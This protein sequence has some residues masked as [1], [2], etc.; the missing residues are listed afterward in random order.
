VSPGLS[1]HWKE[2]LSLS[3]RQAPELYEAGATIPPG[4][5]A[6]AIRFALSGLN[7]AAVFCIEGVPTIAFMNESN[8]GLDRID[9]IH[10]VLWNQGLLS[11]LLVIRPDE[12]MA[13]SLVRR[14]FKRDPNSSAKDTRLITSLSLI[15]DALQLRHL[16]ESTESGRFWYEH[17]DFFDPDQRV[18]KVLLENLLQSFRD[19]KDDLGG[20]AAQA[21][22]MQAMFIAYLED[23]KLIKPSAFQEAAGQSYSNFEQVLQ[24]KS[25]TPFEK[26]FG[27]LKTAFNGNVFHT[28]CSFETNGARIPT[29]KLE[30]LKILARFRRGREEMVTGQILL[31]GYDFQY[32]PIALI[33]AVYDRFLKEEAGKKHAEGAFYTP[34][35]LADVVVDQIWAELSEEQRAS[36]VF[37]DPACGSGI[38]L[39]RLFQRLVANHCRLKNKTHATWTELVALAHRVHGGDINASAVRVA[40]CSLYIA[41]LESS[42]PPNLLT[43]IKKG[44]LLPPLYGDT[45]RAEDFFATPDEGRYVAVVGNPPWKGRAGQITTAQTWAKTENLPDPAKDIAWGFIW[46]SLRV[47]APGGFV[48]LLLPAMG[49]LHNV[50]PETQ[51]A[52]RQF[53]CSTR[54]KRIINLSDLCFQLFDDAQRP[55]AFAIYQATGSNAAEPYSF[56]YWTPKADF[57]LRL[58]RILTLARSDRI[59]LRSDMVALDPSVFKRRLWTRS[60]DEKLLQYLNT[61]PPMSAFI[62]QFKEL[63]GQKLDRKTDWVIGQGFK[64]AQEERIDDPKYQRTTAPDVTK[65]PY[66]DANAFEPV[67]LPRIKS[68]RW[69]SPVVHRAGFSEGFPGPHIIIPQGVERAIGRVRA[70]YTEQGLTFEHSLQAIAFPKTEATTAKLLTAVLNS[71]LAAWFYFHE[72]AN[73]GTDRAKVIQTDLLKLPFAEAKKMPDPQ[74][75]KTAAAKIV[76]LIDN[77]MEKA[78]DTLRSQDDVLQRIDTL[79][80]EY[81]G[82]SAQDIALIEDSFE[83]IIPAMQPR[84]S[85]GAQKIWNASELRHRSAYAAMLCEALQ[86]WLLKPVSAMLTAKS[87]DIAVLKVA[88]GNGQSTGAYAE[89]ASTEFDQFLQSIAQSL[90]SPLPG[91]VQVV[92]DLRFVI[93][94]D[95][96]LVK[97][98]QLR[99][100]LRSAALADAEQIAAELSAAFASGHK[101]DARRARG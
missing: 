98:I 48:G 65:Y 82:L 84:R 37:Y 19:M 93:G 101:G 66:L 99:H 80:Y 96:Y 14:P 31:W 91:N 69:P 24:A 97:P 77:L 70:A 49:V 26:L 62:R 18:D 57:N 100:W 53:V 10:R 13:Y 17:D 42:N 12:L 45:I 28:P 36:G 90:P 43:L 21:L 59:R 94:K 78:N 25:T 86:P 87:G 38:F 41:L 40:V 8:A 22:L 9:H 74:R 20:D 55:T 63:R 81:F 34:M 85:A 6:E 71:S 67:V 33:S 5:H 95:M 79:V 23:R 2:A 27:W 50:A 92:P 88:L 32:M 52:R 35:F 73:L 64:P 61:V 3:R 72:T 68:A 54:I 75:A 16:I 56:E 15:T 58:K 44:K 60:P 29:V 47:L 11:L 30:H 7:L 4:P 46:K 89:A 83:F 51:N 39:V 76:R 1:L